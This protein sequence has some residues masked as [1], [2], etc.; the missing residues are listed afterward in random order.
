M[1]TGLARREVPRFAE[2]MRGLGMYH[3]LMPPGQDPHFSD[4]STA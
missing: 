2:V 3:L 4:D 1:D